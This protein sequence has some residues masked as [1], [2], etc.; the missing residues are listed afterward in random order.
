MN[1]D[2]GLSPDEAAILAVLANPGLKAVRNGNMV[3]HAQLIQAKLL[4]NIVNTTVVGPIS[5][6]RNSE[7]A[8]GDMTT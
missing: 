2:D 5:I 4:P 8:S 7:W 3:A 1:I 6:G